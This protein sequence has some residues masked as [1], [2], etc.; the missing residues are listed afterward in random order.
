MSEDDS[1]GSQREIENSLEHL[2]EHAPCG[3]LSTTVDGIIIRVNE[4]LLKWTGYRREELVGQSFVSF[5][6]PGSQLLFETRYLAVLHLRGEATEVA[7]SLRRSNGKTLPILINGMVITDDQGVPRAIRTA[8]FDSNKRQEYEREL[9]SSRRLAEASEVRVR[10]LQNA[11]STFAAATTETALADE[12]ARSTREAFA[13]SKVSVYLLNDQGTLELA[14]G[15]PAL[16]LM[17]LPDP[18]TAQ[19]LVR[20]PHTMIVS[21]ADATAESLG[22]TN[23]MRSARVE[24]LTIV[25]LL[26]GA[27]S[28][29]LLISSFGRS[30][31]FDATDTELHESLARQAAHVLTRI[32]LQRQLERLALYD[33]LTGLASRRLIRR[34]LADALDSSQV[35]RRSMALI[36][37]DL[38]GFKSINDELGHIVGDGVLNE[39]GSRLSS[40]VR[41]GDMVG[42]FGGDEFVVI[43]EDA[44]PEAVDS[45]AERLHAAIREPLTGRASQAK[46]TGSI[47]VAF[48]PGGGQIHSG[49]MLEQAD[50]AMYRSK[51]AGKN[52]TVTVTVT[53]EAGQPASRPPTD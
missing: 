37:V 23:A 14:S 45:I 13:P 30:R 9:L 22:L 47:G 20:A 5:L 3:H 32:R 51:R 7:L 21:R 10:L 2:Y 26:E 4:T 11:S 34:R 50:E 46:V 49:L 36:F 35:H 1:A 12:L 38:D 39:I 52:R 42:R 48:Y 6:R 29:G 15:E 28:L 31:K 27:K 40:V 24:T 18:G 17:Q 33:Q 25:P 53:P 41:R 16:E 8:I 19:A 43:C 44:G